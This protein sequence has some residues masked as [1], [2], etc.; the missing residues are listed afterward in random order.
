MVRES[1]MSCGR[2]GRGSALMLLVAGTV[3]SSSEIVR[4]AEETTPVQA[5]AQFYDW[6]LD[7]HGQVSKILPQARRF[8]DDA[9]YTEL[10]DTYFKGDEYMGEMLVSLCEGKNEPPDCK[11]VR[12]DPFTN[13]SAVA[14]SY[15]MG[16]THT[17]DGDSTVKL[18][19]RLS[20]SGRVESHVTV[21]LRSQDGRFVISNLQ[22]E[23]RGYYYAGPIVDLRKLLA[24]YNC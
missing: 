4:A 14:A 20:G 10:E 23:P 12:Y 5:V 9:L 15:S 18:V 19:L 13:D 22:F 7:H 21:I 3:L 8:F 17:E 11:N 16:A 24:A 2:I 6:Y 1:R